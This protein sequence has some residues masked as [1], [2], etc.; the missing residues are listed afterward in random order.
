M[1]QKTHV[2][3]FTS[4]L[5]RGMRGWILDA[6]AHEAAESLPLNNRRIYLPTRRA[7]YLNTS[8]LLDF[9]RLRNASNVLFMHFRPYFSYSGLLS[10]KNIRIFI[11]HIESETSFGPNEVRK[12]NSAQRLIFQNKTIMNYAISVGVLPEKCLIGHG[13]ISQQD[14]YPSSASPSGDYVLITGDFKLRKNPI[15]IRKVIAENP[16]LQFIIHGRGWETNFKEYTYRNLK[17]LQ[18]ERRRHP[19]LMRKAGVLLSISLNEGG[20]FPILEALA[21]GTPVVCSA[22]GFSKEVVT[23][24]SGVVLAEDPHLDDIS[25]AVRATIQLK[26]KVYNKNMLPPG[27]DW[28]TF[29]KTL[30]LK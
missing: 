22:T 10:A 29:A 5:E 9:Y 1:F 17:L 23:S 8:Q 25:E 30:Y 16:D 11:T 27:H 3:E 4:V 13:A 15:L 20:P 6:I 7:H 19:E 14:F 21:S 2:T 26:K 28:P 24:R 12:L 18:F